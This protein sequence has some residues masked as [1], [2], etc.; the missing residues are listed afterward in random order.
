[1][2]LLEIT[3]ATDPTKITYSGFIEAYD[4]F[5]DRLF[6]NRLPRCLITMQRKAGANGYFAN[7]RFG[8]RDATEITDE[9]ALNPAHFKQRDT[10]QILSTL[11]HEMCHL[12]QHHFGHPSRAC[13]H[14][15]EWVELMHRVGLIASATGKEGG[16]QTGQRMTHYIEHGG[17][18][19][20]ACREL[21][22]RGHDLRYVELS[23]P[24]V[25]RKKAETK[26]KYTCDQCHQNA[27]GKTDLKL[28][29]DQCDVPMRLIC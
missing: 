29:C 13:Y 16:M 28:R 9:I 10:T 5:N 25:R 23:D 7:K 18:F 4:Y 3:L 17:A 27:W 14:N 8:T 19:G 2:Q 15:R 11:V 26:S 21:I 12:E 24:A 6:D 1:M 22:E 20:R